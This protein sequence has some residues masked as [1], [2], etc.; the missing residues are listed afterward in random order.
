MIEILNYKPIPN[1]LKVASFTVKIPKWGNFL[2]RDCCLFK[3]DNQKWVSFPSRP[4]EVEGKKKYFSFVGF[5][6]L[7]MLKDFQDKIM[8]A[9]EPYIVENGNDKLNDD[10]EGIPF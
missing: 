3:K 5:E 4:Y 7:K 8:Q 10:N 6:D 1:S 2:I 9:L